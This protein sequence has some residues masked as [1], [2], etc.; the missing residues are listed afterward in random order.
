MPTRP[1]IIPSVHKSIGLWFL[2]QNTVKRTTLDQTIPT[3]LAILAILIKEKHFADWLIKQPITLNYCHWFLHIFESSNLFKSMLL[4][5]SQRKSNL[6]I[7]LEKI[8]CLILKQKILGQKF[9]IAFWSFLSTS[10]PD[11]IKYVYPMTNQ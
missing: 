2:L 7:R 9:K 8:D 4:L 5:C 10:P 3:L 1:W 11:F 6:K